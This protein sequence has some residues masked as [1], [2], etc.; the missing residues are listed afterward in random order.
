MAEKI[1]EIRTWIDSTNKSD[2]NQHQKDLKTNSIIT[3]DHVKY[4]I[5]EK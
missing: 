3:A 1:I 5:S 2:V 4:L